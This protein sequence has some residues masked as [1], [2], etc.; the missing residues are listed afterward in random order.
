MWQENNTPSILQLFGGEVVAG[1]LAPVL[2]QEM[3]DVAEGVVT[4][5]LPEFVGEGDCECHPH[6]GMYLVHPPDVQ[7]VQG[8]NNVLPDAM[9]RAGAAVHFHSHIRH[10]LR[11]GEDGTS[12][13]GIMK[14]MN[15]VEGHCI[16]L[17]GE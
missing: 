5:S 2:R 4:I 14:T 12:R 16:L 8:T 15:F 7:T 3:P 1:E 11:D 10:R 13:S 17:A 9:V 6:T